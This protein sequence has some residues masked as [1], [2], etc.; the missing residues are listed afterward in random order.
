MS[1]PVEQLFTVAF[2][3]LSPDVKKAGAELPDVQLHY[4]SIKQIR[5]LLDSAALLAPGVAF[6]TEPELRITGPTGKF[7]VQIKAGKLNF[8]SW[9]SSVKAGGVITPA[10]IVAAIA[11]DDMESDSP[12]RGSR[13]AARG[14]LPSMNIGMLVVAIVAVNAFTFWF[15]TRPPRTLT[16]KFTLLQAEPAERLLTDVAGVY[17]TGEGPGDR[18]LEIQKNGGVQRIKFG[19]QRSVAQ[20]QTYT[21]KAAEAAGKPALVTDKH[22]LITIRDQQAVVLYGDT[23]QRVMR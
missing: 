6:P 2:H 17:E 9:S 13:P 23:Y 20:K 19:A 21:V 1:K 15:M 12:V 7:V 11:G 18:R 16:P 14:F 4:L 5:S 8:V 10:Q 3:H 22:S